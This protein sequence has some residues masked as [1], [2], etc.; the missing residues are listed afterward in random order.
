MESLLAELSAT[1]TP[2][3][4]YGATIIHAM[5]TGSPSQIYGNVPNRGVI[6]NLPQ[7]CCVEAPCQVDGT[8]VHPLVIGP[9]PPQCAALIRTMVN[10]QELAVE[11]ALSGNREH[12]YHAIMLDPL[13]GALLTLDQ[14]R[15]M[16]DDLFAAE[17]PWLP[18]W[19]AAT[20]EIAS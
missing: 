10:V 8:G 1:L 3:F 12:V 2:S 16:T 5:E 7:G 17:A 9:L 14:I 15:A 6:S 13:S 11:A 19:A 20:Q 18:A 4:E